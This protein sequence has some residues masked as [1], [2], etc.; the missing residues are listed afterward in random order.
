M[1]KFGRGF[2][3]ILILMLVLLGLTVATGYVFKGVINY[4]DTASVLVFTGELPKGEL[5]TSTNVN[6][7]V[8]SI[9]IPKTSIPSSALVNVDDLVDQ[10]LNETV[11]TGEF[12]TSNAL[13]TV[14]PFNKSFDIPEGMSLVSV[15]FDRPDDANA[16]NV[17]EG[18]EISLI[19]SPSINIGNATASVYSTEKNINATVFAVKDSRFLVQG[20]TDYDPTKLLYVTF[21]VSDSDA[22]FIS[23][24]KDK[25]RL[26]IIQ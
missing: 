1:K 22:V 7:Y 19:Y 12:V 26:D 17:F 13:S 9:K 25:G 23:R 14:Y 18:Q 24:V 16:W 21:L 5:I 11:Y 20:E 8:R 3:S 2:K 15:R 6:S 10:Y 4:E